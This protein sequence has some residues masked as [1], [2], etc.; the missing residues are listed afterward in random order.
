MK[1]FGHLH[2]GQVAFPG[3]E[4]Q[5]EGGG[6]QRDRRREAVHVVEQVERVGDAHDPEERDED[7]DEPVP[8]QPQQEPELQ[9]DRGEE[10]LRQELDL[11]TEGPHVVQ[12]PHA[13]HRE[14]GEGEDRERAVAVGDDECGAERGQ[15]DAH[16]AEQGDG[17]AVPAV[18]R[19]ASHDPRPPGHALGDQRQEEAP[20][21]RG[22]EDDPV[23]RGHRAAASRSA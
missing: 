5:A 12:Q 1:I 18:G 10:D 2:P 7:V 11:G 8:G 21:E 23:V 14:G 9:E 20:G 4:Q 16:P 19:G 15:H 13:R 3:E 17:L 6:D 22:E